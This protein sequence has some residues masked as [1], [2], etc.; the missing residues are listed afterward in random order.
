MIKVESITGGPVVKMKV[1]DYRSR[2][3]A[4]YHAGEMGHEY[5][6][7]FLFEREYWLKG[8]ADNNRI[9]EEIARGER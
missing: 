2:K 7:E 4:A 5:E 8:E 3:A 6:F 1:A 9:R